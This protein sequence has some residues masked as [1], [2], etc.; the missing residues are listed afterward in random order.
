MLMFVNKFI[1]AMSSG[2]RLLLLNNFIRSPPNLA[3]GLESTVHI[4]GFHP[5]IFIWDRRGCGT[6]MYSCPT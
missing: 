4:S 2:G 5:E 3:A 6:F 1:Y